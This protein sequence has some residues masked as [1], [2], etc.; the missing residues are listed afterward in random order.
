MVLL[1]LVSVRVELTFFSLFRAGVIKRTASMNYVDG[2]VGTWPKERRSRG[3][4]FEI[5]LDGDPN[6]PPCWGPSLRG[7]SASTEGLGG[8]KVHHAPQGDMRRHLSFQPV[9]VNGPSSTAGH[10]TE[11]DYNRDSP[12]SKK[13]LG[14]GQTQPHKN[15]NR[16]L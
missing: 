4:S 9:S 2:C 13:A 7:R 6:V 1:D 16:Y 3:I 15:R 14:R 10:I 8:F 11:E 5:P 12:N